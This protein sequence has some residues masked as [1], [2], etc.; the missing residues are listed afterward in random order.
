MKKN[1]VSLSIK[2]MHCPSCE[3]FIKN[4][5]REEKNILSVEPNYQTRKTEVVYSG[6]LDR[7]SLNNKISA[8]G[9]QIIDEKIGESDNGPLRKRVV[10]VLVTAGL[11]ITIYFFAK[12]FNLIPEFNFSSNLS[13]LTVFV[14]GL[15]A[16]LSTC[17]ATSGTLLLT[18]TGKLKDKSTLPTLSFGFGRVMSYGFFGLIAGFLGRSLIYDFRLG[19]VFLLIVSL[20]MIIVALDML[21]L[22]PFSSVFFSSSRNR[23]FEKLENKLMVNPKKTAFLIGTIIYLLP[24]GFT[25]AVQ[26]YALGLADPLKSSF[27]MIVF[28]IGT[29][30]VLMVIGLTSS[31]TKSSFYPV[32]M[33]VIGILILIIGGYYFMNS[34]SLFGL[35]LNQRK[36]IATNANVT[37]EDG[38]QIVRMSVDSSGYHP[39]DFTLKKGLPV[40]WI[41]NGDNVLG[42]QANFVVPKLNVQQTLKSGENIIEFTPNETGEI[43]FSCAMGMFRGLFRVI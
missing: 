38:R 7:Q 12:E 43:P 31:L 18:I 21:K 2:G 4:K 27:T 25:Q 3:V 32:F 1:K 23:L 20:L 34:L 41:I 10:D 36:V 5:F 30:P 33:R 40:R 22:I 19:S 17:M 35:N 16:S 24:C 6:V 9:Y 15:A 42:C 29:L 11:L 28:A 37:I 8:F 39:N 13:Y 14:L 26:L